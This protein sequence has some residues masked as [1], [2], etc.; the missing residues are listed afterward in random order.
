[1]RASETTS[2]EKTLQATE[3]VPTATE[4]G[5]LPGEDESVVEEPV[6]EEPV[7]EAPEADEAPADEPVPAE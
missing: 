3:D 4:A 5:D 6:A 1:L 7:A 2:A